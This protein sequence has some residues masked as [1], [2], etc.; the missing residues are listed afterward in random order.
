[1][2]GVPAYMG[3]PF[4]PPP[5]AYAPPVSGGPFIVN[6]QP[7]YSPFT[8]PYYGEQFHQDQGYFGPHPNIHPGGYFPPTPT[9]P[10]YYGESFP[11]NPPEFDNKSTPPSTESS[12]VNET[13]TIKET[14][15]RDEPAKS[16]ELKNPPKAEEQKL[17]EPKVEEPNTQGPTEEV[18]IFNL[19]NSTNSPRLIRICDSDSE[20]EEDDE[21]EEK[22]L[23]RR[24][25]N[26][27]R[28]AQAPSLETVL[29]EPEED[30]DETEDDTTTLE[31]ASS[32]D[33]DSAREINSR[34]ATRTRPKRNHPSKERS[35]SANS[36]R[37]VSRGRSS[38]RKPLA[39]E[40]QPSTGITVEEYA[41]ALA[42]KWSEKYSDA[43]SD[44][45]VLAVARELEQERLKKGL[46]K[47][48][49][50]SESSTH[51]G[52]GSVGTTSSSKSVGA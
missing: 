19:P 2:N 50:G 20:S 36:S 46:E 13:E 26:S 8:P 44:E 9:T 43:Y 30:E 17:E 47:K 39:A 4:I 45:A 48:F 35:A 31:P 3:A 33:S 32:S 14:T 51:S 16:P 38:T 11:Q 27:N 15:E 18:D 5:P 42:A 41:R 28:S 6:G 24:R 52:S 21:D 23:L 12:T 7:V 10:A 37:S 49:I 34:K 25:S 1:M 40:Y 22:P 29:E